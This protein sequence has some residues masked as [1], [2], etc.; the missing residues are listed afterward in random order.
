M[1]LDKNKFLGSSLG[2]QSIPTFLFVHKGQVVK[3]MS[4]AD[5]NGLTN[6][7]RWMI[8]TY[9]LGPGAQGNTPQ[10][11]PAPPKTLQIYSEKNTPYYFDIEKWDLPMKKLKEFASKHHYA[12]KPE[13]KDLDAH[14]VNQFGG[15]NHEGKKVVIDYSLQAMPVNDADELVPFVDFIRICLVKE[16]A[17]K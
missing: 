9:N 16:D 13:F 11:A 14:M 15:V 5:K 1:D 3:K 6:N 2:V 12:L 17:A 7:I 4:G 10:L 8:S